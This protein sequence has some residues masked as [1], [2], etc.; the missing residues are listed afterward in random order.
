MNFQMAF[1]LRQKPKIERI[2]V[3]SYEMSVY[4]LQIS[5]DGEQ[6]WSMLI[7]DPGVLAVWPRFGTCL[8]ILW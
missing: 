7:A 1:L 5:V 4:L 3:L 8:P 2:R 6:G